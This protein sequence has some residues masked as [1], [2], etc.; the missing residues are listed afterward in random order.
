MTTYDDRRQQTTD[1]IPKLPTDRHFLELSKTYLYM[2]RLGLEPFYPEVAKN[3]GNIRLLKS[4]PIRYFSKYFKTHI[5]WWRLSRAIVHNSN[6]QYSK[7]TDRRHVLFLPNSCVY[8][9]HLCLGPFFLIKMGNTEQKIG[10]C[11][12]KFISLLDSSSFKHYSAFFS[13]KI[14]KRTTF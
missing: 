5:S 4:N 11:H 6:R 7:I 12:S 10:K 13:K 14:E 3:S 8:M 9:V 1:R 2:V